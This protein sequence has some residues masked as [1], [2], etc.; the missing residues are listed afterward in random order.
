MKKFKFYDADRHVIEPIQMWVDYVDTDIYKKY[1]INISFDTD[2]KRLER[3]NRLGEVANVTLPPIYKVGEHDT[4][5]FWDERLQL[6]CLDGHNNQNDRIKAIQPNTQINSMN[7]TNVSWASLQPTFA[8]FIVNNELLPAEA[9]LAYAKAYNNWLKDYC[10]HSPD[11]LY[12]VALISRHDSKNMLDQ[13]GNVIENKWK[14]IVIRPEMVNGKMLGHPD[15]EEFWC[16]CEEHSIG[17]SL[18]GGTHAQL[19]TA[20]SDRFKDH[21]SLH[22]CSHPMELQMAFVSLL[23]SGVFE[24]HPKLKFAFLEAGA[25]WVPHWLWRLDNICYPEFKSLTNKNIK[26]PPSEYFKRQCWVGFE[27]GEPC[28]REVINIIGHKKLIYGS[29]FPHPDHSQ[30]SIENIE[31]QMPELSLEEISDVL[32]HN[33]KDFYGFENLNKEHVSNTDNDSLAEVG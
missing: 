7:E 26:M 10:N 6:A 1:P 17:V 30:F 21:F 29:D 24:R 8:S 18:H 11:R 15:Y 5:K 9:S 22:A 16:L 19:P 33:S 28:L 31:L 27:I 4:L 25:S 2:D 12:P 13:L 3:V 32:E 23:E 14:T 20:G